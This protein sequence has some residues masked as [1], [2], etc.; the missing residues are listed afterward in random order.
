MI[1]RDAYERVS[2]VMAKLGDDWAPSFIAK[3]PQF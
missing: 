3:T 2:Y 1:Q